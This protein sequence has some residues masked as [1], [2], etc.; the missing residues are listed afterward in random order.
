MKKFIVLFLLCIATG[1]SYAQQDLT[2]Q[3]KKTIQTLIKG[4]KANDADKVASLIRYDF[5]TILVNNK[6]IK[7]TNKASFKK[8]FKGIFSK[9][10]IEAIVNSQ[11]SDWGR[12]GA[13]GFTF[14]NDDVV[15]WSDEDGKKIQ[16]VFVSIRPNK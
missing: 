9:K 12:V 13:K 1:L 14:Q 2:K 16:S 3:D 7:I 4:L 8:N 10:R 15:I 5:N 11:I 6:P